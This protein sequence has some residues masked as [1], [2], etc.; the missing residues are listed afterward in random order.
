MSHELTVRALDTNDLEPLLALLRGQSKYFGL[1]IDEFPGDLL[2]PAAV[3]YMVNFY[4]SQA[5]NGYQ[6]FG[7][8]DGP[9]LAGTLTAD[10][11]VR[12]PEWILRRIAVEQGL[13]GS[14]LAG[15][16]TQKLMAHALD[17]GETHGYYQHKNLIPAKYRNAHLRFWGDQPARA[18]RYEVFQ[19]EFVAANTRP[20]FA[21]HWELLFG[22]MTMPID[23]VVRVSMLKPEF[24]NPVQ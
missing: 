4:L 23:S 14:A 19:L 13:K 3:A 9:L 10:Y 22:R 6:C 5:D 1:P 2:S 20:R 16:V 24:R 15:E 8:F 12:R 21:E 18:G 11:L 17:F 7:C